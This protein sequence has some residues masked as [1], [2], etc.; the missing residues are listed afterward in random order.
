MEQVASNSGK[1]INVSRWFNY[2][3]FDVMGDLAF[4]KSFGMLKTGKAHYFMAMLEEG[5]LP[6]GWISPLPW[7]IPV[8]LRAP[9]IGAGFRELLRWS[10]EQIENRKMMEVDVP[11]ITSWLFQDDKTDKEW[12][13]GDGRLI[14]VAGSD[15]TAAT[16]TFIFY[17]LASDPKLVEELRAELK[18]LM[19]IEGSFE[20]RDLRNAALLNGVIYETLRMHPP[21]PSGTSRIT[22]PE[23]ITVD[24]VYVPGET[25]V[26]V[27]H[28][29]HGR[30]KLVELL[31]EHH[32]RCHIW[33]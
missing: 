29:A 19:N 25:A 21:V 9:I 22:P 17:Y 4:G 8:F 3:S 5:M 28:Y 23:G 16:L 33:V 2:Y 20:L 18:P 26:I 15:T 11:D 24:G 13:H 6:L 7:I 1:P 27:P 14:V 31:S 10:G 12:L 30:C 32:F